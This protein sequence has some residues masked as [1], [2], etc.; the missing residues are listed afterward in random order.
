MQVKCSMKDC[1]SVTEIPN[2]SPSIRFICRN[3]ERTDVK[4]FLGVKR[5]NPNKDEDRK[6]R[7]AEYAFDKEIE[8][9]QGPDH[10]GETPEDH[11]ISTGV[12]DIPF[13]R[14]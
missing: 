8:S 14:G 5:Y 13:D 6:V 12:I 4:K 3:H 9:L 10:D 7:F 1:Q 2:P 11:N